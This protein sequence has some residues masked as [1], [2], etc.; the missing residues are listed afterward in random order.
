M[1]KRPGRYEYARSLSIPES[2]LYH[3]LGFAHELEIRENKL[4]LVF[5]IS[6]D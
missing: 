2:W 3:F 4:F 1:I 5:L 6:T